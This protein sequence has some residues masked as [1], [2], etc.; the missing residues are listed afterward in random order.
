MSQ[1]THHLSDDTSDRLYTPEELASYAAAEDAKSRPDPLSDPLPDFEQT[2]VRSRLP[3]Q[4]A[5]PPAA[6]APIRRA[7]PPAPAA[8]PSAAEPP[9]S[10]PGVPQGGPPSGPPPP[11]PVRPA[12]G[13]PQ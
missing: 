13:P 6:P 3:E 12:G 2:V 11:P 1:P 9:S 4:A 5:P 8:V 10:R 7:P